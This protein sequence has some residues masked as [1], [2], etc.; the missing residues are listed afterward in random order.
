M[1]ILQAPTSPRSRIVGGEALYEFVL[2]SQETLYSG[3]CPQALEYLSSRFV[4]LEDAHRFG[5]GAFTR[6]QAD[7]AAADQDTRDWIRKVWQSGIRLVFPMRNVVGD[8]L[9]IETRDIDQKNFR[10]YYLAQAKVEGTFFGIFECRSILFERSRAYVV[11]SIL[12]V[13]SLH[14]VAFEWPLVAVGT[15]VV[16][17]IQLATL[18]RFATMVGVC[19]DRD[20]AGYGG[21]W[22]L[23]GIRGDRVTQGTEKWS[24][25]FVGLRWGVSDGVPLKG[26]KDFGEMISKYGK[27]MALRV[28]ENTFVSP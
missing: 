15:S 3:G 11:E 23:A 28:L 16:T 4:R 20:S 7:N 8:I 19:F 12:D 6:A 21:R 24:P 17:E 2:R 10:D 22:S 1:T 13:L 25:R 14:E 9:G 27:V 18:R 5:V 26:V